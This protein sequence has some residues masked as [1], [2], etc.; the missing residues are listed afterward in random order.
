[1]FCRFISSAWATI[2]QL[3]RIRLVL[4][5]RNATGKD[6][7]RVLLSNHVRPRFLSHPVEIG[8]GCGVPT[9]PQVHFGGHNPAIARRGFRRSFLLS[10]PLHGSF[11]PRNLPQRNRLRANGIANVNVLRVGL[12]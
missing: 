4:F 3:P 5:L 11:P 8:D 2:E 1:M 12:A 9:T 6:I 10:A 7:L